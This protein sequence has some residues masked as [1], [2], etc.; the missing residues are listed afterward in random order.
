MDFI[1][2]DPAR[3]F[4]C[5]DWDDEDPLTLYGSLGTTSYFKVLE[6]HI[7]PCNAKHTEIEPEGVF[8]VSEK[9]ITDH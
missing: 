3:K 4:F 1:R 2:E 6:F 8:T 5:L 9:C 7:M